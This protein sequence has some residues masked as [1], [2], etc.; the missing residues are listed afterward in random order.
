[1]RFAQ[2]LGPAQEVRCFAQKTYKIVQLDVNQIQSFGF[3]LNKSNM[4]EQK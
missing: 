1:M 2:K 4:N 3:L